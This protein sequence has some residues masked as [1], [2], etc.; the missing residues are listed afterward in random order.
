MLKGLWLVQVLQNLFLASAANSGTLISSWSNYVFINM[1]PARGP[2][3]QKI[4]YCKAKQSKTHAGSLRGARVR[5]RRTDVECDGWAE[6]VSRVVCGACPCDNC[7]RFVHIRGP[8][9][10]VPL[11]EGT[12]RSRTGW[13]MVSGLQRGMR[14]VAR[15]I[16]KL[17]SSQKI[18]MFL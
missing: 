12:S 1:I 7:G 18:Y 11:R 17:S 9:A 13:R 2:Q 5:T 10:R 16:P 3:T 14:R 8:D 15:R 6:R 4:R